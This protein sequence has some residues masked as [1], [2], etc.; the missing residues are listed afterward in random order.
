MASGR[1]SVIW[2]VRLRGAG[3]QKVFF[4]LS[5]PC[6]P[7]L[8]QSQRFYLPCWLHEWGRT[9]VKC[10][11]LNSFSFKSVKYAGWH[12][13]LENPE[14]PF[15]F[16]GYMWQYAEL[17]YF[18]GFSWHITPRIARGY[19]LDYLS[20]QLMFFWSCHCI[21]AA[22]IWVSHKHQEAFEDRE[23]SDTKDLE[24]PESVTCWRQQRHRVI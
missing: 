15:S 17:L 19:Y 8:N 2:D 16:R 7:C 20:C 24:L 22:N 6:T 23:Q 11:L 18:K 5:M 21:K 1:F 14:R 9:L 4:S 12:C 10:L 3:F 13:D